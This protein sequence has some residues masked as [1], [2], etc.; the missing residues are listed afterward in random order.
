MVEDARVRVAD[1]A[2]ARV[3]G[4]DAAARVGAVH[5]VVVAHQPEPVLEALGEALVDHRAVEDVADRV[6]DRRRAQPLGQLGD[7]LVVDRLVH[8]RGA[9]RRAALARG[10]EAAEQRALDREVEVGVV[11]DDHRVLAAE[12]QARRLEVAAAELADLAADRARAGEADLVDQPSSSACSRPA[13]VSAPD[14]LDDVQHAAGH[15]ARVEQ[16][17]QRVAQRGGVL[18]RLPDDGVAAQ[19][20]RDEVPGRHGDREVA[21]GDDRRHADRDAEGEELLVGHLRRH[22]LPVQAPAL[23]EEEV[24]GVDDLLDLAAAPPGTACRSRG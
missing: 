5:G 23:A 8:D 13:N 18:R 15:A 24:A 7:E 6:A 19:D 10:A 3:V 20:R 22:G 14:G 9:Q 2:L 16:P 12:L 11:H 17:R 1:E 4:G 21:G